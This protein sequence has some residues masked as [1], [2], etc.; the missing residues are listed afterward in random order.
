MVSGLT[1]SRAHYRGRDELHRNTAELAVAKTILQSYCWYFDQVKK[2]FKA[3]C[4]ACTPHGAPTDDPRK[5][6]ECH[7]AAQTTR[8]FCPMKLVCLQS[9]HG[10]IAK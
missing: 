4:A 7:E 6:P 3:G 2:P 8:I 1:G 9:E 10:S 5:R